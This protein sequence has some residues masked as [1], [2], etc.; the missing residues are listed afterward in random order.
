MRRE[1]LAFGLLTFAF[2]ISIASL[3]FFIN[4]EADL[5]TAAYD[6]HGGDVSP[7]GFPHEYYD[8]RVGE[9]APR[10]NVVQDTVYWAETRAAGAMA[11]PFLLA[12]RAWN[13]FLPAQA[14]L[15]LA[16]GASLGAGGW[17]LRSGAWQ[18]MPPTRAR[19]ERAG[20][21]L[22]ATTFGVANALLSRRFDDIWLVPLAMQMLTMVGVSAGIGALWSFEYGRTNDTQRATTV[23][24]ILLFGTTVSFWAFGQK[25]H[26]LELAAILLILFFRFTPG[27]S[28]YSHAT[29]WAVAGLAIW[30]HVKSGLLIAGALGLVELISLARMR[31][32]PAAFKKAGILAIGFALGLAPPLIESSIL[33]RDPL[34]VG[35]GTSVSA[36]ELPPG[37]DATGSADAGQP[38]VAATGLPTLVLDNLRHSSVLEDLSFI[39]EATW[40]TW[41]SPDLATSRVTIQLGILMVAP[42]LAAAVFAIPALWRRK[43]P[44][45]AFL[46]IHLAALYFIYGIYGAR[47]AGGSYE[48]RYFYVAYAA[49]ALWS[50]GW[51]AE[52][53]KHTHFRSLGPSLLLGTLLTAGLAASLTAIRGDYTGQFHFLRRVGLA[54]LVLVILW[55]LAELVARRAPTLERALA[56]A[57]IP[58]VAVA[59]VPSLLYL[60][61]LA[62]HYTPRVA[63]GAASGADVSHLLPM[64]NALRRLLEISLGT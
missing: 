63:V 34:A 46:W 43:D 4:D 7:A 51:L 44:A 49:L 45:D 8:L 12:L 14:L 2:L 20:I 41:I 39:L 1:P 32:F 21:M 60:V 9:W 10:V 28:T 58:I 5:A 3:G 40:A 31:P 35:Y 42:L 18:V 47:A 29:A 26:G 17:I 54:A 13:H 24:A 48:S 57:R 25:Y 33:Y 37:S 62:I 55:G 15:S 52:R 23:C 16:A 11:T 38:V 59:L 30:V 22:A 36:P 53:L 64:T 19:G 56:H 61:Q 6:L 27:R 50:G